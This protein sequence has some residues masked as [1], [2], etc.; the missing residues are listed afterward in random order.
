VVQ[1]SR[2]P[3]N[4][5]IN[6]DNMT[7][8]DSTTEVPEFIGE[9]IKYDIDNKRDNNGAGVLRPECH[10]SIYAGAS[11][12][13]EMGYFHNGRKERPV[14]IAGDFIDDNCLNV[15]ITGGYPLWDVIFDVPVE[16]KGGK[17]V[18]IRSAAPSLTVATPLN[19]SGE[20]IPSL[21]AT[22]CL[23]DNLSVSLGLARL[24][25]CTV[26]KNADCKYLQAS[27]CI[28][29]GEITDVEK[30]N[31][32]NETAT[33]FNCLRYSSIPSGFLEG[34]KDKPDNDDD[35]KLA[36]ALQLLD[37]EGNLMLRTN[38]LERSLFDEFCYCKNQ[39]GSQQAEHR[40]AVY[41]EWGYGVPGLLTPHA[42]RFGAED[43]GEMGA[44]HHKYYSLKVE[45]VLDKMR[46]FLPVGIEPVLIRDTRLLRVPPEHPISEE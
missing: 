24:E 40:K 28:F 39:N 4:P 43:G 14:R 20:A 31:T 10:P 1:Y 33:F 12:G 21:S 7:L 13:G 38:T 35:K 32:N 30:Q 11:D 9:R 19:E 16:A 2:I 44:Y 34:I 23:F 6:P 3:V 27:D 46:E 37:S 8:E 15:P 45:A 22:D 42:V 36:I 17:L 41:G 18:L 25:Y 5:P 26:M 29:A